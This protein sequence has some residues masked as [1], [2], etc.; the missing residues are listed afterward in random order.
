VFADNIISELWEKWLLLSTLG[1]VC[2]VA[3]GNTQH[4]LRSAGG[5]ALLQGIFA[6]V[7]AVITA[8]GYQQRPAVTAKIYETLNNPDAA[9]TSSMY[10]DLTQGYD[11][12]ADQIIGDLLARGARHAVATP[13]LNAVYVNL[14]VYLQTR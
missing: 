13:L 7:L 4:I 11:I 8:D 9:M 3:R 12:E 10:R 14:Q 2:C 6:E 5:E 1:A